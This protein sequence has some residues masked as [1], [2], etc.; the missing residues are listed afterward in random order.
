VEGTIRWMGYPDV[1][2]PYMGAYTT[3]VDLILGHDEKVIEDFYWYLLHSTAAHTF[4]EGIFFKQQLAWGHT[5]PHVT[6]AC[7]YAII[8]RHML[9]HEAEGELHLLKAIPDWWLDEGKQIRIE[10]LPT[11]YGNLSMIITGTSEGVQVQF[12]GPDREKPEQ[13]VL[14]LPDNRPLISPVADIVVETRKP[15]AVRW[16]FDKVV[17]DYTAMKAKSEGK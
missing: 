10:R 3:M 16:D 7:N 8:L 12:E 2:H 14:H 13:I 5:I 4:P 15:Q 9:V 1:I 11:W 17:K 6:G